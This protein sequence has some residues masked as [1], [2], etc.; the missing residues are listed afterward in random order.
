MNL[1]SIITPVYGNDSASHLKDAYES[2][3]S[4]ELPPG[5]DFEWI[6][7]EDEENGPASQHVPAHDDPRVRFA[8]GRHGGPGVARTLALARSRGELIKCLDADDI[9]TPGALARDIE[10]LSDETVGWTCC[11]ALDL[12]PDGSHKSFTAGDP[13]GGRIAR[14]AVLEQWR[15]T[16]QTMLM[17]LPGTLCIRRR[18]A[19]A[20]GGWMALPASEDTGLIVATNA[21]S[22]GWFIEQPG[23]LYRKWHGQ[24]TAQPSHIDTTER[25]LRNS[26]IAERGDAIAHLL[27]PFYAQN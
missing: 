4:Q 10:A 11:R 3:T 21:V 18:L 25:A 23:M 13:P 15:A 9:L 14:G 22:D 27:S 16:E 17:V 24:V 19:I 26:L 12:M 6:I 8:S 20:L 2:L 1:I 7:Q 5:W